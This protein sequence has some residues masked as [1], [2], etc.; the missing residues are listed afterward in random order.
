MGVRVEWGVRKARG[1]DR[2]MGAERF[3]KARPARRLGVHPGPSVVLPG[4][5]CQSR[6]EASLHTIGVTTVMKT[7]HA[8]ID[9]S[10][11]DG[12]RHALRRGV[13]DW[14]LTFEGRG[15]IFKHE[16]GALYV[17]YLV[18]HPPPEPLH[19]VA[20]ALKAREMDGQPARP[21]GVPEERDMGL[22]DAAAVRAL[23]RRQRALERVLEDRHEAEAVKVE[24]LRELEEV[25]EFLCTSR[26]LSRH[27]AERCAQAVNGSDPALSRPP[28]RGGGRPGPAAGGVAGVCMAP[29]RAPADSL[30]TGLRTRRALGGLGFPAHQAG[31]G[32]R[33]GAHLHRAGRVPNGAIPGAW[34]PTGC[35]VA[36]LSTLNSQLATFNP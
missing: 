14:A 13:E 15:A 31:P 24:A 2:K 36:R 7:K 4:G 30:E 10:H 18:L 20:L 21:G 33:Q 35:R 11:P 19:A 34:C 26:W 22:E 17:A 6:C 5:R 8:S 1:G 3:L 23:W 27:G 9:P 12:C 28:G 29:V 16:L 32:E 25:T